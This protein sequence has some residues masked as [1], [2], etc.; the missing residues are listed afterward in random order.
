[1]R[2]IKPRGA[3]RFTRHPVKLHIQD[4]EVIVHTTLVMGHNLGMKVVAE[5]I[6]DA[7]TLARLK[8]LGCDLGQGYHIA[9]PMPVRDF[10]DWL[11]HYRHPDALARAL[12]GQ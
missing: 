6:E 2:R 4:D 11:E 9:R 12:A 10:I 8:A 1:M 3:K 7:A 5:G